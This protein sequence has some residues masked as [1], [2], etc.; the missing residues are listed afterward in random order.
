A[1]SGTRF[2]GLKEQTDRMKDNVLKHLR[3]TK[4]PTSFN[5][6]AILLAKEQGA[7][8]YLDM[9]PTLRKDKLEELVKKLDLEL[10]AEMENKESVE[11][12]LSLLEA[13]EQKAP[14]SKRKSEIRALTN[15]ILKSVEKQDA[16]RL[17]MLQY[18][19]GLQNCINSLE[20]DVN[21]LR[22]KSEFERTQT[23][24]KEN[25]QAKTSRSGAVGG[26]VRRASSSVKEKMSFIKKDF[27]KKGVRSEEDEKNS[28]SK[29]NNNSGLVV[30]EEDFVT[31]LQDSLEEVKSRSKDKEYVDSLTDTADS[32]EVRE[33]SGMGKML[34]EISDGPPTAKQH[35]LIEICVDEADLPAAREE[36]L[37][38]SCDPNE[39]NVLSQIDSGVPRSSSDSRL[40]MSKMFS[41]R[42]ED[43]LR[44]RGTSLPRLLASDDSDSESDYLVIDSS[45]EHVVTD[46]SDSENDQNVG[47]KDGKNKSHTHDDD[48]DDDDQ[49]QHRSTV[50]HLQTFQV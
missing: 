32:T 9:E 36:A 20:A 24:P 37:N 16:M 29:S 39:P 41:L 26:F 42:P 40:E 48:D 34:S 17:L 23:L 10:K 33:D 27:G 31:S 2:R 25:E 35:P 6:K 7:R 28:S 8:L 5:D 13:A 15:K 44:Y 14:S 22:S 30:I 47:F 18:C 11:H 4:I 45:D 38:D 49:G 21:I 1:A 50:Q 12:E 43:I 3:K 19:S 46:S